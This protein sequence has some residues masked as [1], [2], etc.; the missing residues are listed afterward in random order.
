MLDTENRYSYREMRVASEVS[1]EKE[2]KKAEDQELPHNLSFGL[3]SKQHFMC[4]SHSFKK[5]NKAVPPRNPQDLI[6]A[7]SAPPQ[8]AISSS[9]P[10]S[11]QSPQP[12]SLVTP[13]GYS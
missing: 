2:E 3:S 7:L 8:P 9:L 11:A 13:P 12:L 1:T 10:F 4:I 6:L 5:I